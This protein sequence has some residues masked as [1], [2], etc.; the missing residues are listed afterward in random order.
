M[1]LETVDTQ[2]FLFE[3]RVCGASCT[4]VLLFALTMHAAWR[5]HI[6][7][8][9]AAELI[10]DEPAAFAAVEA[11]AALA[12][13][14]DVPVSWRTPFETDSFCQ[15]ELFCASPSIFWRRVANRSHAPMRVRDSRYT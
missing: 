7:A 10:V 11:L 4:R 13:L 8:L 2:G 12:V 3:V 5:Q 1:S 6:A 14:G 15:S 9:H